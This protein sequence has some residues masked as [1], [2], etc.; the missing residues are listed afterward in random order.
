MSQRTIKFRAWDKEGKE[1]FRVKTLNFISDGHLVVIGEGGGVSTPYCEV[2]QFT[3]LLD[4]NRN[5]IYE[6]DIVKHSEHWADRRMIS[7]AT[8]I[9]PWYCGDWSV[10]PED[11]EVIGNIYENPELIENK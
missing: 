8:M 7:E 1:M 5:E 10:E 2:M 6:G 9:Y 4:K 3:G 11:C